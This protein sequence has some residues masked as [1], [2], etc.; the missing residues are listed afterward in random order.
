MCLVRDGEDRA[1]DLLVGRHKRGVYRFLVRMVRSEARAEELLSESFMKLYQARERYQTTARFSTYLYTIA[2]R[3][4]LNSQARMHV[5][6]EAGTA[7]E[8]ELDAA[9]S[10]LTEA[11][12]LHHNPERAAIV[13]GQL[14]ALREELA[15]LKPGHRDAFLLY[16]GEGLNCSEVA[17]LL[18]I[19]PAE[20][21][22]RL[23]YTRKLLRVRLVSRT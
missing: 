3:V 12:P 4:A 14:T 16:Y 10:P 2:R 7:T 8:A 6:S 11:Q 1:F 18:Q 20:A 19:S 22:G 23:A 17:K 15:L 5:R 9:R 13:R 21:K